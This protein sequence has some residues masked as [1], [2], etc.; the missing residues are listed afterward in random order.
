MNHKEIIE[1]FI[2]ILWQNLHMKNESEGKIEN[3]IKK[4]IIICVKQT[5]IMI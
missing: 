2:N 5:V 1:T 4:K 3:V